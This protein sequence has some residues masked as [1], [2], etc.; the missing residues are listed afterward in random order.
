MEIAVADRSTSGIGDVTRL[1]V[2]LLL[3]ALATAC[4]VQA[5]GEPQDECARTYD[6]ERLI[7][8]PTQELALYGC[9]GGL[10][11]VDTEV[12]TPLL[13]INANWWFDEVL[14][15]EWSKAD[16][17]LH[18]TASFITGIGPTGTVPF[19][20]NFVLRKNEA[21]IWYA[22]EVESGPANYL[23]EP[24]GMVEITQ[25]EQLIALGLTDRGQPYPVDVDF[26]TE[27]LIVKSVWLSSGSINIERVAI[28]RNSRA[29]FVT[30]KTNNPRIGTTDM[31]HSVVYVVLPKDVRYVSFED[32]E[33][34]AKRIDARS[35]II[36]RGSFNNAPKL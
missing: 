35:G 11:L 22:Q 14:N 30:Y 19:P 12:R 17:S 1:T 10:Y 34:D 5:S 7:L 2:S 24:D 31:K 15:A 21:G 4:Q 3:M 8:L 32:P 13:R 20:V 16:D 9:D 6:P 36:Q 33:L 29:Y 27:R 25:A 23:V 18:L 26:E 28:H